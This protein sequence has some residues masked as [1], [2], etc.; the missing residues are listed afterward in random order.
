[1]KKILFLI[2][3]SI[4]GITLSSCQIVDSFGF[5]KATI[6]IHNGDDSYDK[7]ITIAS[8]K[9]IL[10]VPTK[11]GYYLKGIYDSTEGGTQFFYGNGE[12]SNEWNRSD[13]SDLYCQWGPLSD[14]NYESGVHSNGRNGTVIYFDFDYLPNNLL[15]A[16]KSNPNRNLKIKISYSMKASSYFDSSLPVSIYTNTSKDRIGEVTVTGTSTWQEFVTT[17]N[18]PGSYVK[19]EIIRIYFNINDT[20]I[21]ISAPRVAV[22]EIKIEVSY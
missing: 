18:V 14:I 21:G 12:V 16:V 10:E 3:I 6:T 1:M 9:T 22:D 19:D 17:I 8:T 7:E 2:L 4:L 5:S 11:E 20:G 13:S 15:A